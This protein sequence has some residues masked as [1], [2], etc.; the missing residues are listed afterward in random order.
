M[1]FGES[2]TVDERREIRESEREREEPEASPVTVTGFAGDGA[3]SAGE[4]YED[5]GGHAIAGSPA[6]LLD[7][8][9][10]VD[11][12]VALDEEA[13]AT[14]VDSGAT[15]P[16]LPV[17]GA[18]GVGAVP[19]NHFE[20]ALQELADG[21]FE[22]VETR[23]LDVV[24]D[25]T[26]YRALA[27]VTLVTREPAKISEFGV[28]TVVDGD[29]VTVDSVRADGMVVATPR[30]SRGYTKDARG[31]ILSPDADTVSVVPIAPFRIDRSHWGL[32]PPVTLTVERDESDVT[33]LVDGIDHGILESHATVDLTWG[34]TLPLVQVSDSKPYFE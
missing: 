16:V 5:L 29:L 30:G 19:R 1:R 31:P 10:G 2:G 32:T 7:A 18:R 17:G 12:L 9:P 6:E 15:Q 26:S 34:D 23:L 21:S 24:V 3:E 11:V 27:D 22:T 4:A 14:L 25:G 20:A 13:L 28:E 8:D 33:I